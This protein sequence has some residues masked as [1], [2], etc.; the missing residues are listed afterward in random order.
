MFKLE[1]KLRTQHWH[2]TNWL[3]KGIP[4][5]LGFDWSLAENGKGVTENMVLSVF[6]RMT[7]PWPTWVLQEIDWWTV[8][9]P[10]SPGVCLWF[11]SMYIT[12]V[13]LY[14]AAWV[15]SKCLPCTLPL[16]HVTW[17]SS[18]EICKFS[19]SC[20][21]GVGLSVSLWC[22][23]TC[24]RNRQGPQW[25]STASSPPSNLW[26]IRTSM[27]PPNICWW[28]EEMVKLR[29]DSIALICHVPP[30]L[31]PQPL[32]LWHNTGG[33]ASWVFQVKQCSHPTG[34]EF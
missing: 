31:F 5:Y 24:Q 22:M 13:L 30:K 28:T 32:Y 15:F 6:H 4:W 18:T 27:Q 33:G 11:L 34:C 14:L 17:L 26:P 25:D 1:A 9:W 2:S 3:V 16:D 7:A 21:P 10:P 20:C 29:N 19:V 8:E 12:L 23:W